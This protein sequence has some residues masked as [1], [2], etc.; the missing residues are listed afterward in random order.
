MCNAVYFTI[1]YNRAF[2]ENIK[3]ESH[4]IYKIFLNINRRKIIRMHWFLGEYASCNS[5]SAPERMP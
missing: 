2:S 5:K 4:D 3:R 1:I